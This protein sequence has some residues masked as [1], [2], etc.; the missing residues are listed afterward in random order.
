MFK[1]QSFKTI[2]K[3]VCCIGCEEIINRYT[4]ND[5]E[6]ISTKASKVINLDPELKI[7]YVVKDQ[8]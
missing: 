2:P 5:K 4:N 1:K 3:K 8:P 6:F 7:H